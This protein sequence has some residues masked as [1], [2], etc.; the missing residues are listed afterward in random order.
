LLLDSRQFL[1]DGPTPVSDAA[2][3]P[4]CA[5]LMIS[6]R[7][8][9]YCAGGRFHPQIDLPGGAMRL[10][11]GQTR[12]Y[13]YGGDH[14]KATSLY[15]IDPQRGHARLCTLPYPVG[16]ASVVG[17]T[18]YFAA[19][20]QIY[21][22]VPGGEMTLI[23]HL[24]GPAVT[25]LAAAGEDVLY[26]LAGRTLYTWQAGKAGMVGEGIGDRVCWQAG[27]LYVLDRERQSLLRLEGLPDLGELPQETP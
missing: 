6:G 3:T 5:L 19:S 10:A 15:M 8:L 1:F 27:A 4:D 12:V 2:F 14:D 18:L 11:V 17:D 22:L 26:F 24:P 7:K 9:G 20:S 23:C 21:R 25:S 16:A 13:V